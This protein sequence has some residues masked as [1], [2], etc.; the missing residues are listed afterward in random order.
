MLLKNFILTVTTLVYLLSFS[1]QLHGQK[2][3]INEIMAS[4]ATTLP[5]EDGT[6]A[7]WIEL[8]NYGAE[9]I[10]LE[11]W[12]LTDNYN[13]LYK[14]K[15][16]DV[17]IN[18]NCCLLIWASGKN[19]VGNY[20]H[21]NF[22]ISS[23]GEGLILTN[24]DGNRVDELFPV[25]L[26]TDVSY[27]R[28]PNG[29][30]DFKYFSQPTAALPNHD[31]GFDELIS[32]PI[33][34][35]SPGFYTD[36]FYLK[37]H[38]NDPDVKIRYT[39]DGSQPTT[40]SEIFPDSLLIRNRKND[41]DQLSAIPTTPLN[42]SEWF[43]WRPPMD[44]VFKGTNI[45]AKA[46]KAEGLS[47]YSLTSTFWVDP[48]IYTRYSLPVISLS[49]NADD[50]LGNQGIYTNFSQRGPQ[51]ERDLHIAFFEPDGTPGFSTDAGVRVNGGNSRRYALKSF[52]IYFRN[53]YGDS[54]IESPVFPD[55]LTNAHDRLILR[56]AGSDWART[57]FRD[58]F[59]Q[60]I[61]N[62]FADLDHQAYRP[63]AVFLNGEYWGVMNI[64]EKL[65][66]K[67]I[68][69]HYGHTKI[70]MLEDTDEVK[71]GSKVHYKNLISFLKNNDLNIPDNYEWVKMQMDVD[72]FRDYHI[73]QIF[74]MNTDQPGKNVRFWR[75]QTDIG[76]WRW[77]CWDMDD[78]FLFGPHNNYNRNGLVFC[79]GLDS[80]NAPRVNASTPPPSWAPNGTDQ[81]FPLRALLRSNEFSHSFINRFADLLNTAFQPKYLSEIIDR[82]H[83]TAGPNLIEH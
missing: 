39:L 5:D 34:S 20:L 70:D 19:R 74:C 25:V 32:P 44:V 8:Y 76:K 24:Q 64:R 47:P 66:D 72:N 26:P 16:P 30:G 68:E 62:G 2:I 21:S 52:R 40:N 77:M 57:Y 67:Y 71:Y 48:D 1:S 79:S 4:N 23:K 55:Q 42:A 35:H 7:D 29:T 11:G 61:L 38:H 81:T 83:A 46:F 10:N 41:P 43:R 65:D 14:W 53:K 6:Y 45:R 75:P 69:N 12:T 3:A 28:F 78:T 51:W 49:M 22:A 15:F 56:N 50:L 9:D 33:I 58:P 18:A 36:S 73:L 63:S 13:N 17:T 80:I 60:S 27:G 37:M 82:F 59:A 31:D 54:K